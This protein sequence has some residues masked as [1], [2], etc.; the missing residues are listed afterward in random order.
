MSDNEIDFE[1]EILEEFVEYLEQEEKRKKKHEP[2]L[3]RVIRTL[4]RRNRWLNMNQTF[5]D[6]LRVRWTSFMHAIGVQMSH[7]DVEDKKRFM[8]F[9][10]LLR[11]ALT[12]AWNDVNLK[13]EVMKIYEAVNSV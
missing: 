12:K 8:S 10:Q 5:K 6:E 13:P 7:F 2:E 4:L 1:G 3:K 11:N 9:E